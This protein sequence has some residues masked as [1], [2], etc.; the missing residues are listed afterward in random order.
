MRFAYASGERPLE[1]YTI[2]RG[3]GIGG[4]GEVY[5]AT[6]DAGKDV[7]L[8]RIQRNLDVELRGVSHCLNV[9][10]PNLVSLY[11]IRYDASGGGW[12]VM[13]F[14]QGES[15]KD[16]VDRNPNGLPLETVQYWL[17][18][19]CAGAAYLHD[20]GVVHRDLKPGN[21]FED[22][23]IVKI[24]D[25]GLSKFISVSRRSGQTESVGTFHYMAPEIGQGRYGREIDIYAL[26]VM[27]YEMITG[28]VPFDGESSQE[29]IMKHLTADPDLTGIPEPYRT[30]IAR[31]LA[32]DP[33]RRISTVPELLSILGLPNV[34][35]GGQTLPAA[36]ATQTA[37]VVAGIRNADEQEEPIVTAEFAPEPAP[38]LPLTNAGNHRPP[39][40]LGMAAAEVAA[41]EPL[42]RAITAGLSQ[43]SN[44]WHNAGL[45]TP[46]NVVLL[47]AGALLLVLNAEWLIPVGVV[48]AFVYGCYWLVWKL[49]TSTFATHHPTSAQPMAAPPRA[50]G[51]GH[52]PSVRDRWRAGRH[53]RS[54]RWR[55]VARERIGQRTAVERLTD[56]S[57]SL[58]VSIAVSVVLCVV[59]MIVGGKSLGGPW[60][61]WVPFYA[62]LTIVSVAGAW[63]VL[64]PSHVWSTGNTEHAW[65]RFIMLALGL[66]LGLVA[67][68][69]D[70]LLMI[71]LIYNAPHL[72][73][74]IPTHMY[75]P[76]GAPQLPAY[77]LFFGGLLVIAR[78]W[79]LADPLRPSRL[80]LWDTGACVAWAWVLHLIW[81]FPQ[82]WGFLLAATISIAVQLSAP[83]MPLAAR[84]RLREEIRES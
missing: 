7:A 23:G 15:L 30:A 83:W 27:L 79:R 81:P 42:A 56:V 74:K 62:W 61:Q 44:R 16:V 57:G 75:T 37:N 6:S 5:Y 46:V 84:S 41:Q 65:R 67:Y 45:G 40:H 58:L 8:K 54:S 2:K 76:G 21:I 78:W 70:E 39:A 80:S 66:T 25:Y 55:D 13:E 82:P 12:V 31:S 33:Q 1:G 35:H 73:D 53:P 59:M 77:L 36:G 63:L 14:V 51:A 22:Q 49:V 71:G 47:L 3:V 50:P 28:N 10:H 68:A 24:G 43:I 18:G 26:G 64:L 11:D 29:I 9:K 20:Q 34:S 60:Q 4:F 32:K 69:I 17:S 48:A 52:D 38:A 72:S 19:I